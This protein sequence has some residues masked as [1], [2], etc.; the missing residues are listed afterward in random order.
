MLLQ[1]QGV[2]RG[3]SKQMVHG[4]LNITKDS[5]SLRHHLPHMSDTN[6][7]QKQQDPDTRHFLWL[8]LEK[9]QSQSIQ[10]LTN[11]L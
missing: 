6:P 2:F 4:S 8:F 3:T 10:F 7:L 9:I 5:Q 11:L 1:E